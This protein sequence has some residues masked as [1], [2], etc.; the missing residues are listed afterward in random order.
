MILELTAEHIEKT[1]QPG[2][3]ETTCGFLSMGPGGF[4]CAKGTAL[5][6]VIKQ[7]LAAGTISAKGDNCE[8]RTGTILLR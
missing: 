2:Q 3:G 6:G 4:Q 1:C 5:E 8:G 7:R